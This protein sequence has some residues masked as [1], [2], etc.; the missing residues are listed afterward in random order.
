M[1]PFPTG[2]ATPNPKIRP[3]NALLRRHENEGERLIARELDR[4]RKRLM[5]GINENN[6]HEIEQRMSDPAI[7]GKFQDTLTALVQEWALVGADVG[8][9]TIEKEILG[10]R[11]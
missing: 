1:R 2:K 9:Q 6:V 4:L 5:R 11:R 7:M 10:V 3:N 8:R